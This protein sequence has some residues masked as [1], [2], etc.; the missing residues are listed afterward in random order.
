MRG[1]LVQHDADARFGER[2]RGGKAGKTGA[3]HMHAAGT[4]HMKP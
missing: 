3:H 4:H 2:Q 1:R